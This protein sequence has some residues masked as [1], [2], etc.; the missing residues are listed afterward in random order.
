MYADVTIHVIVAIV[1]SCSVALFFRGLLSGIGSLPQF[2]IPIVWLF[3][4][5][6]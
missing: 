5:T 4:H 3:C 6:V 2:V 1:D